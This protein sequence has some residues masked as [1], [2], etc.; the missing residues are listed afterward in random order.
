MTCY[1]CLEPC[2]T[3]SPCDCATP[4]HPHC[5]VNI[6]TTQQTPKC[7]I[8]KSTFTSPLVDVHVERPSSPVTV[9]VVHMRDL[10]ARHRAKWMFLIMSVLWMISASLCLLHKK[11]FPC[12]FLQSLVMTAMVGIVCFVMNCVAQCLRFRGRTGNGTH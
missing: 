11:G 1:V 5:F 8:C 3:P 6:L 7:S 10:Q 9:P 4:L 2:T 12:L